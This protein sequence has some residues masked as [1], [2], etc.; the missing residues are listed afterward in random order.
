M[1]KRFIFSVAAIAIM[2]VSCSQNDMEVVNVTTSDAISLNPNTAITRALIAD[3]DMLKDDKKGF[4]VFATVDNQTGWYPTIN[5]L[6]NHWLKDDGKWGFKSTVTWPATG[7]YPMDFYAFYPA[8]DDAITRSNVSYPN[9]K[10]DID[11]TTD[12]EKQIDILS[13]HGTANS[14]PA[15]SSLGLTFKHILSK[16][17]FSVTNKDGNDVLIPA[18]EQKAFIQAVGFANLYS[19]NSFDV[20]DQVW[21][22][23]L[24]VFKPYNYYNE[25]VPLT[26]TD[27]YTSIE[28]SGANN[29]PFYTGNEAKEKHLMLLPQEPTVWVPATQSPYNLP[30]PNDAYVQVWYRLEKSDDPNYIGFRSAEDHP[31]YEDSQAKIDGYKG[32]LFVKAGYTY[33]S[34]WVDGKGYLYELPMPGKGGGRLLNKY[35]YDDQGNETDLEL[36]GGEEGGTIITDDD[37]IHLIPTVVDWDNL[38][39]ENLRD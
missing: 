1:T 10:L 31:A 34:K 5:G 25:F 15:T 17:N 23:N 22:A 8:E 21:D 16:I 27:K 28:F 2:L 20:K 3:Y 4:A 14:K 7:S 32:P 11:I 24:S 35:L 30:N 38:S 37:E 9:I 18:T 6:N 39:N 29:A 36:P 33:V 19:T 26:G 13:T 12:V